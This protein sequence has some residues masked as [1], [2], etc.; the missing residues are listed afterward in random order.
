M[1]RLVRVRLSRVRLRRFARR[2]VGWNLASTLKADI[3]PLQ[4]LNMAARAADG[5]LDGLV[6]H[7]EYGSNYLT[8]VCTERMEE[9]GATPSTGTIGDSFDDAMAEAVNGHSRVASRRAAPSTE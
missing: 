8:V 2:I 9:I 6:H 3:L 1:S 5:N 4:A 7:A